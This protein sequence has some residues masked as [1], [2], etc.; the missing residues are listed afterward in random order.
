MQLLY[1]DTEVVCLEENYR[2]SGAIL[3]C[4]LEVIEQDTNRPAKP[5]VPTHSLGT[6]PVLRKLPSSGLEAFWMVKEISRMRVLTG[7]M[8]KL[9]DIAILVRSAALT[10][11]IESA[12][13][14]EGLPYVM[15]GG[16]RFFDRLEVRHILD[17][18]R[19]IYNPAGNDDVL[20]IINVPPRKIGAE[21]IK[22]LLEESNRQKLSLWSLLS[23]GSYAKAK[24]SKVAEQ[25]LSTFVGTV[26]RAQN[27][28][29]KKITSSFVEEQSEQGEAV[30]DEASILTIL[31]YLFKKIAYK[32]YIE[33]KYPEDHE[34]RWQNVQELVMQASD[35]S[36]AWANGSLE[37]EDM[38]LPTID[39]VEQSEEDNSLREV[40]G[41]FLTNVALCSQVDA[42]EKDKK[43]SQGSEAEPPEMITISTI[44]AAKGI[45]TCLSKSPEEAN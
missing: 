44:H 17:Y 34:S 37:L 4:A 1:P 42:A 18:L 14:K 9:N 29:H 36:N 28:L 10:R 22:N 8:I 33:K 25:N 11:V 2:S 3:L 35:V 20:S 43:D 39:G 40:L 13:T 23:S 7:R 16:M 5:L 41:N 31:E 6:Q 45:Y 12:L 38:S 30:P 21:S 26:K 24:L 32:E 15:V 27:M 19:V